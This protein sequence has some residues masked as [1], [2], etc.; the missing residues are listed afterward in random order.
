M[1]QPANEG[2]FSPHVVNRLSVGQVGIACPLAVGPIAGQVVKQLVG[3]GVGHQSPH[4]Q[5][6]SVADVVHKVSSVLRPF[7]R[8]SPGE[9]S[10]EVRYAFRSQ[11]GGHSA[12]NFFHVNDIMYWV[13]YVVLDLEG[14]VLRK[15]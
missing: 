13:W 9:F 12:G 4:D 7:P 1:Q 14:A 10:W 11:A 8:P 15:K 3:R 5:F 6:P 2:S